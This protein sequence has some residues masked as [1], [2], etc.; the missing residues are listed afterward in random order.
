MSET[1]KSSSNLRFYVLAALA[2]ILG[3]YLVFDRVLPAGG[4]GLVAVRPSQGA[5]RD[6]ERQ[7]FSPYLAAADTFD[8]VTERPL[9]RE[10]RRRSAP[11]RFEQRP[12]LPAISAQSQ[13]PQSPPE[14]RV[15]GVAVD[16]D[17]NGSALI[18]TQNG[19]AQ[20]VFPGESVEGWSIEAI[21]ANAVVVAQ[22]ESRWR[23]QVAPVR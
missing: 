13:E 8:A 11:T 12:E 22:G 9:F 20:R 14:F 21:S 1:P 23:L 10:T 6:Q 15:L 18:A 19:A 7:A 5:A 16:A 3:G 2:V 17:G 4:D